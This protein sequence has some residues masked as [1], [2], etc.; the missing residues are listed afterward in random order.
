MQ[1]ATHTQFIKFKN[2]KGQK[3]NGDDSSQDANWQVWDSMIYWLLLV[4]PICILGAIAYYSIVNDSTNGYAAL[5][6]ACLMLL[7]FG[8]EWTPS[9]HKNGVEVIDLNKIKSS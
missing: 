7:Y 2:W 3:E 6:T 9:E 1:C 4:T 5:A 8:V